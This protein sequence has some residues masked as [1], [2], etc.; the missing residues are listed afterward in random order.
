[1]TV[2]GGLCL[3]LAFLVGVWG[4]LAGFVGGWQGRRDLQHSAR[5][6]VL[7]MCAALFVAVAA[8]EWA[9][10]QHDFNVEYVA[11]Y[12]SRNLP[13][14]YTWS[15]LYAGQKG[16][17]LFWATVLSLFGSL[18][19]VAS[20]FISVML[21]GHANPFQRLPY[22]PLD[23]SGLNPQLQNPGMVFHPP[24]LY[25]GYISTT[26]PFAFAIA[27][28]LSKRLDADWLVA[29]RKWTLLSWLF[30]SIGICLG[31]WWAYVELGWGGYWAWDPVEN[32]SLL[33]WLTMTAFLHSVMVQEKRGMLKKWN[34]ALI[35]GIAFSVLW[36]TLFPI[37]SELVQGTKVTVGPPFFNQVNVPLGLALLALTGIGPLIAWRRASLPNLRRQFAVPATAGGF[38]LLV[39]LVGGMRDFYALLAIALG[40]FVTATI[41]QE[42][43]RGTRA[44]HRQY[45]EAYAFALAR[46]LGRNRRRYGGYIVHT[47]IVILFVA[48]AGMAF[49]TETEATLR[50]G[51][52]ASLRSP[53]G[54]T[55]RLTHLG[56]SQYDALNRQV[57]AATLEVE[58]DGKRLG[59]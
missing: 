4:A 2:L 35:I 3:W 33:P 56:I 38:T 36:G 24:M 19:L 58:R 54:W 55:Y 18:A 37:L 14:F 23:G 51:E 31:M 22:T 52:S 17:L 20:F 53:Y 48:F 44:R 50:P 39:L 42:F 40:G 26:I 12:T 5:H 21:F 13:I 57:T 46:L 27:A 15:A 11:A 43:A 8:L 32:A 28:L 29:I 10:F 30:L 1:M 25:L 7:A 34:L 41:V 9:L 49:K 47:G 16:S 6:A 59:V 45:G